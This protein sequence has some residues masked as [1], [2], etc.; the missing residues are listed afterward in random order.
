LRA[1]LAQHYEDE[2]TRG[3]SLTIDSLTAPDGW[4]PNTD[5][6]HGLVIALLDATLAALPKQG[7]IRLGLVATNGQISLVRADD[8]PE[9]DLSKEA[10]LRGRPLVI[11]LARALLVLVGGELKTSRVDGETC[12]EFVF[13]AAVRADLD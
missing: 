13:S 10:A 6:L 5:W 9:E 3:I 11:A 7:S 4:A 8:G 1:G 12:V 2:G